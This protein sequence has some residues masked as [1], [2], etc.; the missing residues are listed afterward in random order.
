MCIAGGDNFTATDINEVLLDVL[1]AAS[2]RWLLF[3]R[4]LVVLLRT[5]DA[6]YEGPAILGAVAACWNGREWPAANR[7]S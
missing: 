1:A 7:V 5:D 4:L 6:E 3:G 2:R